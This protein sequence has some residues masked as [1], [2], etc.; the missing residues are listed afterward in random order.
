MDSFPRRG[1]HFGIGPV[2]VDG[3]A[4]LQVLQPPLHRVLGLQ[5]LQYSGREAIARVQSSELGYHPARGQDRCSGRRPGC[6]STGPEQPTAHRGWQQ[7]EG[8]P[9]SRRAISDLLPR[10]SRTVAEHEGAHRPH[11]GRGG[12]QAC[13]GLSGTVPAPFV[14]TCCGRWHLVQCGSKCCGG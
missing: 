9:K 1:L 8:C 12:T 14:P 6:A 5:V 2:D 13:A 11:S 4:L 10:L 3:E 7:G